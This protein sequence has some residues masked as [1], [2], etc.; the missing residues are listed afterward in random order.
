MC[1]CIWR[2]GMGCLC[3][4]EHRACGVAL[5]LCLTSRCSRESPPAPLRL[6]TVCVCVGLAEASAREVTPEMIRGGLLSSRSLAVIELEMPSW[7]V[8]S[9]SPGA[10]VGTR[11]GLDLECGERVQVC[12]S[13]CTGVSQR[14]PE[15]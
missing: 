7:T 4:M 6:P 3:A 13:G 9:L 5:A 11:L 10:Q 1:G 12:A 14:N 15:P 8:R 2:V